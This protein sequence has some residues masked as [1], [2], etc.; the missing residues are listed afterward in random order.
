MLKF[1]LMQIFLLW[2]AIFIK[3]IITLFRLYS[4]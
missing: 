3:Q 2:T 4:A 1:Y